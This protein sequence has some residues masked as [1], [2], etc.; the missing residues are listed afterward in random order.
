MTGQELVSALRIEHLDDTATPPLWSSEELL[1]FLNYAEVQACRRAHLLIDGT[2]ANDS[3]TAATAGTAG[4]KPLCS[5]TLLPGQAVYNLSPKILQVKRCQLQSMTYPLT[6]PVSYSQI[7]E[8]WTG[9]FGTSGTVGTSGIDGTKATATITSSGV[10]VT[11]GDT[12]T[13]D[14]KVY[15]FKTALTPTEGEVLIGATAAATM[16]NLKSAINHTGTPNTDYKC[17][18]VHPTVTATTNTD[19]GTAGTSGSVQTLE[20]II[21]GVVSNTIA[22]TTTAATLTLSSATLTGGIDSSGFP[23]YFLNEPGNTIT[24]ILA[25][26]VYTTAHL[27]VSRLPLI[28]FTLSTSPEI[29]EHLHIGLVDWAAHLA[30]LKRDSDTFNAELAKMYEDNFIRQF[31]PLPDAYSERMR[32]TI[33]Q[34]ARVRPRVFGS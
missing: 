21:I 16:D 12:I 15:T 5:L 20:A 19:T 14:T 1:R 2:T 22:L 8:Y 29:P 9:W 27:V 11:D 3:G 34:N 10:N 7:D 24:F 31:G 6:G 28:P 18:A 33:T 17:A 4:Q 32:K 25:P 23:N 26:S 30:Y 13:I